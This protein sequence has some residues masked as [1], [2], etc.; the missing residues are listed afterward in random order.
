M[1]LKKIVAIF[2]L[3]KNEEEEKTAKIAIKKSANKGKQ[4][5]KKIVERS[6]WKA[7]DLV[8]KKLEQAKFDYVC[9]IESFISDASLIPC[10]ATVI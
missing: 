5:L 9:K 4:K 3:A 8:D 2:F 10:L 6:I 1:S 7:N